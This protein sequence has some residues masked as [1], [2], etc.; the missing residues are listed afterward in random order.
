MTSAQQ[1]ATAAHLHLLDA[2]TPWWSLAASSRCIADAQ[3]RPRVLILPVAG[4]S[5]AEDVA[6]ATAVARLINEA[7]GVPDAPVEASHDPDHLD[8]VGAESAHFR[9]RVG[10]RAGE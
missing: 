8:A 7:A 6:L 3:G 4:G 5:L 1:A 2:P 10:A 9:R